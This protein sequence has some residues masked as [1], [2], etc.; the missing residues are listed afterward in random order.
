MTF[1]P[2]YTQCRKPHGFAFAGDEV[3]E[4]IEAL[5]SLD[6]DS[7][8]EPGGLWEPHSALYLGDARLLPC[9]PLKVCGVSSWPGL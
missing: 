6:R 4:H 7:G 3:D 9:Q 1:T 5:R 2:N 8:L